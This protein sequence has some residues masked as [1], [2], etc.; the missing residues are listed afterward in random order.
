MLLV[1]AAEVEGRGLQSRLQNR[2][3]GQAARDGAGVD[4]HM[5]EA[6]LEP[7]VIGVG[8]VASV[9]GLSHHLRPR[10]PALVIL[11]GICGVYPS[12][13]GGVGP[14]L[15]VGDVCLVGSDRLADEGVEHER[16]FTDIGRMGFGATGP[17]AA[18]PELT[19]AAAA[20]L[21]V[22]IVAGATVSTCSGTDSRSRALARR[23]HA[24]V[25]TMEGAAVA[26]LCHALDVPMIQLRAVS[27][28]TGD[29][30]RGGWSLEPAVEAV[31]RALVELLASGA[32]RR[33][34]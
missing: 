30:E 28:R 22:P 23:S 32:L 17:F 33:P 18:D 31:Q 8:K 2:L 25:E 1:C 9:V 6:P 27:N 21:E 16:G 26:Y 19:A 15:E 7:Q 12:A 34:S 13:H 14:S 3:H 11:F 29:R 20:A 24:R 5:S 4:A 10:R